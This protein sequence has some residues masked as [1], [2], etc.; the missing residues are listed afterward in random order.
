MRRLTIAGLVLVVVL[1]VTATAASTASAKR[2]ILIEEGGPALS[3][4][5]EMRLDSR[6]HFLITSNGNSVGEN[7]FQCELPAFE[8]IEMHGTLTG[9]AG[10]KDTVRLNVEEEDEV[11]LGPCEGDPGLV[12]ASWRWGNEH[13]TLGANGKATLRSVSIEVEFERFESPPRELRCSYFTKA[14]SGGNAATQTRQLLAPI[15]FN[16]TLRR[17]DSP[18]ACPKAIHVSLSLT[19][20]ESETPKEGFVE[21]EL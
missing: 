10:K 14:L 5:S 18:I 20:I 9:I 3:A 17:H 2:L 21:E 8:E 19:R 4:G 13:M 16:D 1:A 15:V 7:D 12:F 11:V 6:E